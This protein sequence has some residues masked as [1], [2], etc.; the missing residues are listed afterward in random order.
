M[1]IRDRSLH[2]NSKNLVYFTIFFINYMTINKQKM[3]IRD[4]LSAF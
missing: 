4:R 3:C 2:I 1:C